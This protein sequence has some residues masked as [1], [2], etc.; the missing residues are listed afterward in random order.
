MLSHTVSKVLTALLIATIARA[1]EHHHNEEAA[2]VSSLGSV[3][4]PISC[5][6]SDQG[7]FN[8]GIALLHSFSYKNARLEF[9]QISQRD[10]SCA[11][12]YWGHA[13]SLYRQLWVR[14]TAKELAEGAKLIQQAK[15]VPVQTNRERAFIDAAGAFY[16][17]NPSSTF[18]TRRD[19]Y[20]DAMKRVH[21]SW[22]KDQEA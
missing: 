14:P 21:T 9:Q 12:A 7:D 19:A 8:R 3:S 10:P 15:A 11:M 22:P 16:D 17:G 2:T 18:E 5:P 1:Q 6:D 4:F 13:M 20:S